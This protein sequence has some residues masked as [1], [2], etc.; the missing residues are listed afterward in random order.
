LYDLTALQK[1]C[2]VHYDMSA[3]QTLNA[4]Q[5]LYEKKLISYPR[6]GSRYIPQDVWPQIP[7]LLGMI[8]RMD[9]FSRLSGVIDPL[10]TS[11][12]SVDDSK[13]TDH[14]A[15]IITGNYVRETLT[16]NEQRVYY[17]ICG[18]MLEAFGP[19]CEKD[20]LLIEATIGDML[21]RSRSVEVVSAGW[22]GVYNRP[23]ERGEEDDDIGA[24]GF[25]PVEDETLAVMGHSLVKLKTRPKPLYTEATLLSAM[26]VAG[27]SVIDEKA[28]EAMKDC[29]LGTPATRAAIIETLLNRE[30][31]ERSGKSL[32]PTGRGLA[33][34]EAIRHLRIADVEL[35]GTWEKALADIER[36][37]A[38][39]M[40]PE[41][42]MNAIT[43]YT[44]QVTEEVLSLDLK[45]P[46]GASG[47]VIPCPKCAGG[48]MVIR[49]RLAKCDDDKCGLAVFRKFLNVELTDHQLEQLLR[50]GST[51]PITGFKGKKDKTFDAALTFDKNFNITFDFPEN[52]KGSGGKGDAKSTSGHKPM[53]K[54][55]VKSKA[56]VKSGL[57][58]KIPKRGAKPKPVLKGKIY[59]GNKP[60]A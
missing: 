28:R 16:Q 23:E 60:A 57:K 12:R 6:T 25:E 19:R 22:R 55:V 29:G 2:N 43:I 40:T 39:D 33:I 1:D 15:L 41:T 44:K 50:S 13:V 53:V 20:T 8:L 48:R 46:S 59:S 42:F 18:R 17:L 32:I 30:Y 38:G 34:Y 9:G 51:K 31:V 56:G 45:R 14:H 49:H 54:A 21:F 7:S 52:K 47:E 24:A 11:R 37:E 3:E 36:G 26:E 5:S 10:R 4:A 58:P 27:K 35:T